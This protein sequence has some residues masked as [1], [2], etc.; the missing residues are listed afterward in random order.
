MKQVIALMIVWVAVLICGCGQD[1]VRGSDPGESAGIYEDEIVS[2]DATESNMGYVRVKYHGDSP[3]AKL[4]IGAPDGSSYIY[5]L[6]PEKGYEVFPFSVGDGLYE[7]RVLENAE[8]DMYAVAHYQELNVRI[9]NE[10]SPFL[11]PNQ[12]VCYTPDSEA[13][14]LA[15]ELCR[16]TS[17]RLELVEQVYHYVVN[18]IVYDHEKDVEYDYVPDV[19]AILRSGKGICFDYASVMAAMLRSL[20]VP[21]KLQVGY[22][23]EVY[24]AWV[25]VYLEE[26][27]WID[28]VIS[29]D[30]HSWTLLDPT[31]A[32]SHNEKDLK[33]FISYDKN[34]KLKY[35]Y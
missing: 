8:G 10:F 33:A 6:S 30:G 4:Q 22:A 19:D 1:M 26:T 34:Y 16:G 25:S 15:Q 13:A 18:H 3:R 21:T 5:I 12:Y 11:Y 9:D 14:V 20:G 35:T 23:K 27:G 24:H 28:N 7:L 31:F 17:S 29:F 2:I 32:A